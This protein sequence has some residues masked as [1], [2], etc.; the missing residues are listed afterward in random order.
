MGQLAAG[1]RLALDGPAVAVPAVPTA[2][3]PRPAARPL[4]QVA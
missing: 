4:R 2:E 3:A 1:Y